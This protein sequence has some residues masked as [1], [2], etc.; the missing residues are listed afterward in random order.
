MVSLTD[1]P[2]TNPLTGRDVSISGASMTFG[3]GVMVYPSQAFAIDLGLNVNSGQFTTLTVDNTSQT[4]FDV[5]A[6][7][8]RINVG[9]AWWP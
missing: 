5:D 2:A 7:S 3:G 8:T 6:T 4:G 1:I 9:V